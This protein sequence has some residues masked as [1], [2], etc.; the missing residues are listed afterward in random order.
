MNYSQNNEQDIIAKH[1]GNFVG[2]FLDL[3]SNDGITLSNTWALTEKGWSGTLVDASPIAYQRL[4]K[5]YEGKNGFKLIHAAVGDNNG[6]I[7][8][9]ES[10]E[11]LG[12]GDTALVSSTKESEVKR[13]TSLNIPFHDVTVRQFTFA[14]ILNLSKIKTFDLVSIDIEGTEYEIVPQI[15][16]ASLKTKMAIIE[17][18]GKAGEY[19]DTILNGFG[20]NIIDVNAENRIYAL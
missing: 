7:I 5:N 4:V 6:E 1:F 15:D 12:K 9:H 8:L 13:W 16:F 17:W 19:Y 20:L 2:T 3:G 10:G 14:G 18:N 11:L